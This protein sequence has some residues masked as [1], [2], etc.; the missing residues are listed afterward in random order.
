[1]AAC[2]PSGL[3]ATSSITSVRVLASNADQPFAKPG[4]TVNLTVLAYDGRATKPEPMQIY[5]L[6]FV[7]ENPELDAYYAC[8]A[9]IAKGAFAGGGGR[10][11]G[12]GGGQGGLGPGMDLTP[13]LQATHSIGPKHSFTMPADAVT[14]HM[15][16]PGTIPYGLAILFNIACAG[17]LELLPI[18]PNNINPQALPIGCFDS[19]H[20][21]LGP[22]DYV[23]GYTRVYAYD[24]LTNANPVIDHVDVNNNPNQPLAVIPASDGQLTT[25][26]PAIPP[27]SGNCQQVEIGPV[28]PASSQEADPQQKDVNG[29]PTKEVLWV[30]YFTTIGSVDDARLVYDSTSGLVGDPSVTDGKFTPPNAAAM[31]TFWAVVHDNRGGSSWVTIPLNVQ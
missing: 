1:L 11:A 8:F 27:C 28:V 4:A 2:A 24:T 10:G 26:S 21:Q 14:S 15:V 31:G 25:L 29:N 7:C 13:I 5:W 6:P 16:T 9:Q 18:D 23:F 3:Q 17:H 22:D 30:D 19:Q 20:N 12:A